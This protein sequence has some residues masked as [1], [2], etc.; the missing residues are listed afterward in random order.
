MV[1]A[2]VSCGTFDVPSNVYWPSHRDRS[3][4]VP[5]C[6]DCHTRNH[7]TGCGCTHRPAP[8]SRVG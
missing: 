6:S 4:V 8:T 1:L 5:I 2:C 3:V 7:L